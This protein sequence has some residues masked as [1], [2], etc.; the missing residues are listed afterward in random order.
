MVYVTADL[1]G[2]P[3]EL[4]RALLKKARFSD[5]D[6]LFVLGDVID[7]NGDGGIRML[8]WM[9]EQPNVE[10]L[11][12]NHEAML[13]ACDFLFDEITDASID[14]LTSERL[15]VLANWLSNGA[16]PTMAALRALRAKEPDKIHDI[17]DYLREAPL[18]DAVSVGNKEYLLVHAGLESFA[19]SRKLSSYPLDEL[20]WCRPEPDQRYFED[21]MTII[22]HTP[23]AYYGCSGRAFHT[24]TWIDIDT[25]AANGGAPMLL[26][27]D[28]LC[29][30]YA[31]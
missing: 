4:F 24:P 1:H 7:R 2:Y 25:G 29:E 16:Q 19:P 6:F 27:L 28:D 15:S 11:L 18:F 3:L 5:N 10:L 31:E 26:R 12:G 8:Q 9:M 13:L 23:T 14:S 30:F 21:V 22:G 20:T 17:L